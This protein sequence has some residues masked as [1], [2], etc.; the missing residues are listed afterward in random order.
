[1]LRKHFRAPVILAAAGLI[2][3]LST[4]FAPTVS[5]AAASSVVPASSAAAGRAAPAETSAV[6][7]YADRVTT[8]GIT[9][10][11]GTFT[12]AR[13]AGRTVTVYATAS[14][15]A[16]LKALKAL[17]AHGTRLV[18]HVVPHSFRQLNRLA[19]RIG[20]D[21][22]ALQSASVRVSSVAFDASAGKLLVTLARPAGGV[23]AARTAA[24]VG[25]ARTKLAARYGSAWVSVASTTEPLATTSA[26]RDEDGSPW[27]PGDGIDL[28]GLNVFCSLGFTTKGNNS[29]NDFLLTAGHCGT[30]TVTD[31]ANGATIGNVSTQ[32]L[33]NGAEDYDFDTIRANG[34]PRVWY[35]ADNTTDY[36]TV[37]GQILPAN[38]SAMTVDGDANAGQHTGNTVANNEYYGYFNDDNYGQLYIGPLVQVETSACIGGDSGGPAYVREGGTGDVDAVGTITGTNG[39]D[40]FVFWIS[41]E[42][43]AGNVSLVTG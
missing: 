12:S 1:V 5:T 7:Q 3:A 15:S 43:S 24:L 38:G 9:R 25:N 30:G 33:S 42:L 2:A 34:R 21:R 13:L 6:T 19:E 22:A 26:T 36:Y 31:A 8:V 39:S 11:P 10:F 27:T 32:Y 14:H 17:P 23:T 35:G 37:N 4:Q 29:G 41:T 28:T 16:L 18:V 20:R 40:C